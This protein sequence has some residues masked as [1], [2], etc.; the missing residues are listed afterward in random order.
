M[1]LTYLPAEYAA[2][3]EPAAMTD[4]Q[5]T[6]WG[7]RSLGD[8]NAYHGEHD[9]SVKGALLAFGF[10]IDREVRERAARRATPSEASE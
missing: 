8:F 4:E 9:M 5:L 7:Q 3:P 1:A 2:L 6:E 10:G